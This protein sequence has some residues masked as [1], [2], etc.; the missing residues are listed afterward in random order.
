MFII[1]KTFSWPICSEFQQVGVYNK[2]H[3]LNGITIAI[4]ELIK[5]VK[6]DSMEIDAKGGIETH[7]FF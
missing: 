6:R 7:I 3:L 5:S 4:M 2:R 1:S